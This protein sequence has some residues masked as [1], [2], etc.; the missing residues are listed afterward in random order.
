M[1]KVGVE[2]SPAFLDR[3]DVITV[4]GGSK[5]VVKLR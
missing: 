5:A 4:C 1:V 3:V 2:F